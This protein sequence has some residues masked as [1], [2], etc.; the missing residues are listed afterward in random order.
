MLESIKSTD[1]KLFH[2]SQPSVG[3]TTDLYNLTNTHGFVELDMIP[4]T[5]YFTCSPE[6]KIFLFF[7]VLNNEDI[8]F[9]RMAS[10]QKKPIKKTQIKK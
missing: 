6:Y 1:F 3:K 9:F 5:F 8:N 2:I 4:F 10:L 7:T